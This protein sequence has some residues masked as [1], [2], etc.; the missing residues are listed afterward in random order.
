MNS[1]PVLAK[2]QV[3]PAKGFVSKEVTKAQTICILARDRLNGAKVKERRG[4]AGTRCW[5]RLQT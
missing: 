5:A 1:I 2:A 3:Y 4:V